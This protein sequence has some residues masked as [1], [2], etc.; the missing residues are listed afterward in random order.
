MKLG[1]VF[2]A[3]GTRLAEGTEECMG[4]TCE[5]EGIVRK[6]CP[7]FFDHAEFRT[8]FLELQAPDFQHVVMELVSCGC[9]QILLCPLFLFEAGHMKEDLPQLLE[10]VRI[11]YPHIVVQ[12]VQGS[13]GVTHEVLHATS[14]HIDL[15]MEQRL[16]TVA[17]RAVLLVG[18]G[19][20]DE[21]AL[22]TFQ[23]VATQ[24]AA[25]TG[26]HPH[27]VA[28]ACLTGLG[29]RLEQ[30]LTRLVD[31]GVKQIVLV[32]YLLFQG[33]LMQRLPEQ[34]EAWKQLNHSSVEVFL[35]L[36]LARHSAVSEGIARRICSAA[37]E[38]SKFHSSHPS[39]V[40]MQG[41]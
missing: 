19:S 14:E 15:A 36:P 38:L 9:T 30:G 23:S 34:I 18:R 1:I 16:S 21:Q 28:C 12:C 20:R 27:D 3:H 31:A 22:Q 7:Y 41:N 2:L 10:Q 26:F 37:A 24:I 17:H 5:I 13:I 32:P 29:L 6:L 39:C 8:A 4:F 35:T 33:V 11:A 25:R 40:S